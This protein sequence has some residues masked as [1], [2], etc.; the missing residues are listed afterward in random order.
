[1][2]A[3]HPDATMPSFFVGGVGAGSGVGVLDIVLVK[4][5]VLVYLSPYTRE[6]PMGVYR[7]KQDLRRFG[8]R[9]LDRSDTGLDALCP[10]MAAPRVYNRRVAGSAGRS[11]FMGLGLPELRVVLAFVV[12]VFGA[13]RLPDSGRGLGRG[14]RH[15]RDATKESG[16]DV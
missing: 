10:P 16:K 12:L 1:V 15:V 5:Q 9:G 2:F 4:T 8:P 6:T 13:S 7:Q 11:G 3:N 14:I